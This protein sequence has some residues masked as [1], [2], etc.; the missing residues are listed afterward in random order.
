MC[1]NQFYHQLADVAPC[2]ADINL[3]LILGSTEL[4]DIFLEFSNSRAV[5][6][7]VVISSEF[8]VIA[9]RF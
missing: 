9:I 5:N 6:T 2:S 3:L 8:F 1:H 7:A 4:F